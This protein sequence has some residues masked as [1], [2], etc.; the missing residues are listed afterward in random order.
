M[1][2]YMWRERVPPTESIIY[3]MVANSMNRLFIPTYWNWYNGSTWVSYNWKVSIDWWAETIYSWTWGSTIV[4]EWY[5]Q[6][7]EHTIMIQPVAEWYWWARAYSWGNPNNMSSTRPTVTEI[8]YDW[9]YMWYGYSSTDT[10]NYFRTS[11]YRWCIN[12]SKAPDEYIPNTVTTIWAYFRQYQ[13]YNCTWLLS[14]PEE[15][16]P[17]AVTTISNNFR[18]YQYQY[19]SSLNEIKWW[20]DLSVWNNYYRG[21]QFANCTTNKTVKV[22]SNVWYQSVN[23]TLDNAY[24]TSVSV[25]NAYLDTFKNSNITPRKEITDSKFVWY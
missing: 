17:D 6:W 15:S 2:I 16:L 24:V 22:L 25:P 8:V 14:A 12:L 7:T 19:C 10:W 13:Y 18:R 1:A 21:S 5:T 20:K 23:D 4:L 11:Q 9:S 3:K